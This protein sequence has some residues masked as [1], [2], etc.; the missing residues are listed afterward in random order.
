MVSTHLRNISQIGSFPKDWGRKERSLKPPPSNYGYWPWSSLNTAGYYPLISEGGI[1]WWE[2][3]W[4][5]LSIAWYIRWGNYFD[6]SP[7]ELRH[8]RD[9]EGNEKKH[10]WLGYIGDSTTQLYRDYKVPIIRIPIE[11][12]VQ[13]KVGGFFCVAHMSTTYN[14]VSQGSY[15]MLFVEKISMQNRRMARPRYPC[16]FFS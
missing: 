12:P 13:W 2:G 10:G 6:R 15:L 3:G 5:N 9:L 1:R 8:V 4:S 14:S 7:A 11:E 16:F